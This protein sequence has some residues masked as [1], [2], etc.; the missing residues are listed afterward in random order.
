M[1]K[2]FYLFILFCFSAVLTSLFS[3]KKDS[4]NPEPETED[5]GYEEYAGTE[6]F[7]TGDL[8]THIPV[9]WKNGKP[10]TILD[11]GNSGMAHH[12]I[13]YGNDLYIAGMTQEFTD[14]NPSNFRSAMYWKNEEKVIIDKVNDT[15]LKQIHRAANG[16][17]YVYGYRYGVD[18]TWDT[19]WKNGEIYKLEPAGIRWTISNMLTIGNDFYVAGNIQEK[20]SSH[21]VVWKNGKIFKHYPNK[22]SIEIGT[23]GTELF[24]YVYFTEDPQ[25]KKK[26]YKVYKNSS[27]FYSI[28]LTDTEW[29]F[30]SNRV[31]FQ[32]GDNSYVAWAISSK[33]ITGLNDVR[34]WK[35]GKPMD[36]KIKDVFIP[37]ALFVKGN[38]VYLATLKEDEDFDLKP[39][40]FKNNQ[41]MP[42]DYEG[43]NRARFNSIYVK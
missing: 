33:N 21:A 22:S 2:R 29:K 13:G 18:P 31:I 35:N 11:N 39:E 25:T 3:C 43:N 9:L 36:I 42:M 1:N 24:N 19:I 37:T 7:I 38:D 20:G 16:D 32:E 6:V 28:N 15:E 17:I 5:P 41:L 10:K 34:V 12:I 40:L 8:K 14:A 4:N 27:L 30:A 23:N 26:S